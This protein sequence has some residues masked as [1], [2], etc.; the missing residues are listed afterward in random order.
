MHLWTWK[1]YRFCFVCVVRFYFHLFNLVCS[2]LWVLLSGNAVKTDEDKRRG[3]WA[4]ILNDQE[5]MFHTSYLYLTPVSMVN[6]F[7]F[8][9]LQFFPQSQIQNSVPLNL[10]WS[11]FAHVVTFTAVKKEFLKFIFWCYSCHSFTW[12]CVCLFCL[13]D[14]FLKEKSWS[15]YDLYEFI[16]K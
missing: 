12:C 8:D 10:I 6:A 11:S 14:L 15:K 16:M 1:I 7:L 3:V 2:G 4:G 5:N 9:S 13:H